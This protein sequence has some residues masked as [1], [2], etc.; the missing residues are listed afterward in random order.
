MK[1]TNNT[2]IIVLIIA[3]SA[4]LLLIAGTSF[5]FFAANSNTNDVVNIN[6]SIPQV[7]TILSSSATQCDLIIGESDMTQA[8]QSSTD[9]ASS[10]NCT[11]NLT[12]SGAPGVYCTYDVVLKEQ[13][14]LVNENYVPYVPT[15]GI[16]TDYE[17]EF[18]GTLV[19]SFSDATGNNRLTDSLYYLDDTNHVD[20]INNEVQMDVLTSSLY[21]T[22]DDTLSSS[23]IAR[24]IIGIN[25]ENTPVTHTYTFTEKWYNLEKSQR[26]HLDKK[27][28]YK[29]AAEN[30]VC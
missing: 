6:V 25:N 3:V 29:L 8:N 23:V 19:N 21:Y 24:G 17:F 18:T 30:I 27:Y 20:I 9:A 16:G 7:N 22:S 12:L 10:A 15:A 2:N 13:S 14:T 5:A 11:L 28:I 1:K 26:N 4:F